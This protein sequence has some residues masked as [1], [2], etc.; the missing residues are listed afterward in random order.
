MA[1]D[2][3]KK[4][5]RL[6]QTDET[7]QGTARLARTWITPRNQAPYRPY[8]IVFIEQDRDRIIRTKMVD[9]QPTPDFVFEVLLKAMT[10][11]TL[12]AGRPRRPARLLLDDAELVEALAPRLA[13]LEIGCQYRHTLPL[14]NNA[15]LEMEAHLNK[16]EPIPGLL[17]IPGVTPHLVGGLYKAAAFYYRQAPWRWLSDAFP[18][19]VRYPPTGKPRYAVVMGHGG[20]T[21]GLSVYSS[22]DD[23]RLLYSGIAPEKAVGQI[24]WVCIV[25]EEA[26]AASFDDLDDIDKYGWPVV[27]ELAYP[28]PIKVTRTGDYT[29]PSK[30]ELLWFEAAMLAIPAFVRDYMQADR[31]LP[32][33]AEATL[34][35]AAADGE[36]DIHLCYPAPGLWSALEPDEDI[37]M[38]NTQPRSYP[39][40]KERQRIIERREE[41]RKEIINVLVRSDPQADEDIAR[42]VQI[43]GVDDVELVLGTIS[44]RTSQSVLVGEEPGIYRRYR[45]AF[46]CFGGTR[47]LLGKEEFEELAFEAAKM[48]AKNFFKPKILRRPSRR[49]RELDL[50]LT[51]IEIWEDI[52]PEDRPPHPPTFV[53]PPA[54]QY[55]P[56]L[57]GLLD[58]GWQADEQSVSDFARR[59]SLQAS[60]A[61]D[62]LRLVLDEGLRGGWPAETPTWAPLHALRLL[63]QLRAHQTAAPLLAL[64]EDEN[65]WLSDLLPSVWAAMGPKATPP[66]WDHLEQRAAPPIRRGNVII[67]L[68]RMGQKHR[69]YRREVVDRFIKLLEESPPDDKEANGYVVHALASL[70]K[71]R[72]AWPAIRRAYDSNKLDDS[73]VTLDDVRRDL[74]PESPS[75]PTSRSR[76]KR[77]KRRR[78]R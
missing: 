42:L 70:L 24:A 40:P 9:T 32:H 43:Y 3:L 60:H 59:T 44:E 69:S 35:V 2:P 56:P 68:S 19:E 50:L 10:R 8:V 48:E 31:G 52:T 57:D 6:R 55:S 78:K 5:R 67:G 37:D 54:G 20:E 12:G 39:T 77:K 74:G 26:L 38:N 23:L 1:K 61:P 34:T 30:S 21:Y 65:D 29:I 41:L 53:S 7:W 17:K 75:R 15:L 47:R 14:M 33:P 45:L 11:P 25:F 73:I 4:A 62:L 72:Q 58:L 51:G 76:K 16:R 18:I 28:V 49:Q 64:M 36:A 13:E 22:S 27:H 46:A 63:G 66:L 71:A